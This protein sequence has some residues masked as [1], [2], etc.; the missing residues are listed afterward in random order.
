MAPPWAL[1]NSNANILLPIPV[2]QTV[3]HISC[4]TSLSPECPN[5]DLRLCTG[6]MQDSSAAAAEPHSFAPA[7]QTNV[8][9]PI[10]NG[11]RKPTVRMPG[12]T[13]STEIDHTEEG[14]RPTV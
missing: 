5:T 13:E 8:S 12:K 9:E 11:A 6:K 7:K 4:L 10:H 3:I 2:F 1:H 14:P